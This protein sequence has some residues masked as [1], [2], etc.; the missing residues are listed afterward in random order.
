ML[1][2]YGRV[3]TADQNPDHQIDAL[4]RA[5]VDTGDIHLDIASGAKAS[6]PKFDLVLEIARTGDTIVV[7]RLDRLGRSLLH[8]VQLGEQLRVRGV[9]LKVI[10][11]GVDTSTPEGRAM[12]GMLA[13]LAEFQRDLI[14]ANTRDGLAAAKARGRKGGRRAKL[15]SAQI[16][17][18]QRLYDEGEHTAQQI[19]DILK[20]K[21]STLYGHLD[22]TTVGTRVRAR[23][24]EENDRTPANAELAAIPA[25]PVGE[26]PKPSQAWAGRRSRLRSFT[27]PSCGHEP[28][29]R[30]ERWQQR[31]DLA[32]IWL[33]LDGRG[34][35]VDHRHC[36]K[37]QPRQR[38]HP[39]D[40]SLCGDGPIL[41]GGLADQ[42]EKLD[43]VPEPAH[44]WLL[45]NGW[46]DDPDH[47]LICT[48]HIKNPQ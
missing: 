8:L 18:A 16:E 11:Q 23:K 32:V 43:A 9:G 13:V 26:D 47:G 38:F 37:C 17:Q 41:T 42:A 15:T 27:C 44:Q 46:A 25:V 28:V 2:G 24:A 20:V 10:E 30:G 14:V 36:A 29:D 22:K 35:V 34:Q 7:T 5:G 4:T 6:R 12:F 40:C 19:A 33:R 45:A 3:S 21:R 48:D 31:Q 39:V 1:I